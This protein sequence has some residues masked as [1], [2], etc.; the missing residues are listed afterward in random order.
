MYHVIPVKIPRY[1][2]GKNGKVDK[3]FISFLE[4]ING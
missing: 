3:Q 2:E 1:L 4:S